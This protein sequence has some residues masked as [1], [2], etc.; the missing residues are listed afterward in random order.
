VAKH[1][2]PLTGKMRIFDLVPEQQITSSSLQSSPLKT[3]S[4]DFESSFSSICKHC[5][6]TDFPSL[7]CTDLSLPAVEL[8]KQHSRTD[9][10]RLNV[11]LRTRI[12]P[13]EAV[14][15]SDFQSLQTDVSHSTDSPSIV[16]QLLELILS[17]DEEPEENQQSNSPFSFIHNST[18]H[19]LYRCWSTAFAAKETKNWLIML[20]GGGYFAA[21]MF[22]ESEGNF[23][24]PPPTLHKAIHKYT[25]R[26]GQ[27]TSQ[28]ATDARKKCH[29]IGS[30][31]RRRNEIALLDEIKA[32]FYRWK[33]EKAI[34]E[35][36]TLVVFCN[37]TPTNKAIL[38]EVFGEQ[39]LLCSIP[40]TTYRATMTEIC[41]CFEHLVKAVPC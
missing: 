6:W 19:Q 32:L 41:R 37:R 28:S 23:S 8:R 11:A 18:D 30:C 3:L 31:L 15:Y 25:V 40:F 24:C 13:I 12:P 10:H 38:R 17:N 1:G 29:S 39:V 34:Y 14:S 2:P 35:L 21:G 4:N 22:C 36:G 7:A 9:W 5:N 27:G 26:K 20:N 16:D 33:Q